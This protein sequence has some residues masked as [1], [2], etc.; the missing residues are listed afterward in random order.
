MK[1]VYAHFVLLS[2]QTPEKVWTRIKKSQ[3]PENDLFS[4]ENMFARKTENEIL[5]WMEVRWKVETWFY[6][7]HVEK[8]RVDWLKGLNSRKVL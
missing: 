5:T 1:L 7:M 8:R 2:I 3:I 6:P 4:I